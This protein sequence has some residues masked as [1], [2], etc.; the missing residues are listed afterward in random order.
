MDAGSLS[1]GRKTQ[2]NLS[3]THL[4]LITANGLNKNNLDDWIAL[5]GTNLLVK[6]YKAVMSKKSMKNL[7]TIKQNQN[8]EL[9]NRFWRDKFCENKAATFIRIY[10]INKK[11]K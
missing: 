4:Q 6:I 3:C 9:D 7:N 11:I 2:L 10:I 1:Q 8:T 5:L